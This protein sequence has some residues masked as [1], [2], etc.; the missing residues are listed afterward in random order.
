MTA[1][2][3][4]PATPTDVLRLQYG[5]P[6]RMIGV[7]V[8]ILGAVVVLSIAISALILRAGGTLDDADFNAS[9]L[10]S[11]LGYT[12]AIGVQNVS[13]SF[14][15]ALALGSTRR[16]FV[17]GNLLTSLVQGLLVAL[18]SVVLLGLE[19]VTG[20]W[21]IG[22]R[23][24]S[25]VQLGSGNALVLAGVMLLAMLCALSAGGVFGASWVRFGARGPLVLSL[26]I[27]AVVVGLLLLLV[28]QAP[29]IADAARPWWIAVAGAVVIGLAVVGQYL[30]L[31]RASVR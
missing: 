7:P 30:L 14:P 16:A 3:A 15:F 19:L 2:V 4:R 17:L 10:Y 13:A 11:V 29:A 20:G 6:K 31:R 22:A 8:T 9:V 1:V 18:V 25:S 5:N 26:G 27:A 21:F 23:A 12:V 24:M 28:P